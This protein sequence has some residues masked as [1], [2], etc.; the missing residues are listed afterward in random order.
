M[1]GLLVYRLFFFTWFDLIFLSFENG[2]ARQS[3]PDDNYDKLS[4]IKI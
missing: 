3:F 4:A 1:V 2:A